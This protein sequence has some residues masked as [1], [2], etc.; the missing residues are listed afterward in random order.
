MAQP[1]LCQHSSP[2]LIRSLGFFFFMVLIRS[3]L[4]SAPGYQGWV[5][6]EATAA[7]GAAWPFVLAMKK[8][9]NLGR[10]SWGEEDSCSFSGVFIPFFSP[11]MGSSSKFQAGKG[12][13]EH[14]E[15]AGLEKAFPLLVCA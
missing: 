6:G 1:C 12:G 15:G 5:P 13:R 3:E 7:P 2:L 11:Y 8:K 14:R 10:I 9:Q 4:F